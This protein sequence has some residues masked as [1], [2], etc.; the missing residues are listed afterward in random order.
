MTRKQ[1]V[2]RVFVDWISIPLRV[3]NRFLLAPAT[4]NRSLTAITS[5]VTRGGFS[6]T[7]FSR[8]SR[9]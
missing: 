8:A 6:V 4:F 5:K 3:N 9:Y 1:R 2:S 7:Q